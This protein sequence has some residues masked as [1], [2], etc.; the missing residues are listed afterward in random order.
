MGTTKRAITC[1]SCP[2]SEGRLVAFGSTDKTLRIWDTREK[3]RNDNVSIV[4]F[5]SHEEWLSTLSWSPNK[6]YI[7]ASGSYDGKIKIWDNRV[8][9]PFSTINADHKGKYCQ[10]HGLGLTP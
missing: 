7:L 3:A 5:L 4:M 2:A 10:Y 1:L 9:L 8:R 6:D